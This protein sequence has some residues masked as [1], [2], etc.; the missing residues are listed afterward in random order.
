MKPIFCPFQ[1]SVLSPLANVLTPA[2]HRPRDWRRPLARAALFLAVV[3]PLSAPGVELFLDANSPTGLPAIDQFMP[4][5]AA[6]Q[7][8]ICAAAA[9]AD[10]M[11]DWSDTP[12]YNTA[13]PTLVPHPASAN[14]PQAWPATFGNW[15]A[16]ARG[17]RTTLETLIYGPGQNDGYGEAGGMT[18]YLKN[19]KFDHINAIQD[20]LGVSGRTDGL[21][22]H[23]Y[24]GAKATYQNL[25]NSVV[26]TNGNGQNSILLALSMPLIR[27]H[28][29][30][31]TFVM[32]GGSKSRHALDPRP[33]AREPCPRPQHAMVG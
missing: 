31:G 8:G 10:V 6:H 5:I 9:A 22:V 23:S 1:S 4:A 28:N 17:L 18:K 12:P 20:F 16:D 33:D 26:S 14:P 2:P 13:V 25:V 24:S 32:N 19:T 30:D 27:W 3:F 21:S 29:A 15:A 11:W 7:G